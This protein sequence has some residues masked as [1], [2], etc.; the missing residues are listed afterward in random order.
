MANRA[1]LGMTL[2]CVGSGSD[3]KVRPGRDICQSV[4]HKGKTRKT[5]L[6]RIK[7]TMTEKSTPPL[8]TSGNPV[9]DNGPPKKS[10]RAFDETQLW[11]FD[12]VQLLQ[13]IIFPGDD[14]DWKM[15]RDKG[16]RREIIIQG[17]AWMRGDDDEKLVPT[18]QGGGGL[19]AKKFIQNRIARHSKLIQR[20]FRVS[21]SQ[22]PGKLIPQPVVVQMGANVSYSSTSPEALERLHLI[23][24]AAAVTLQSIIRGWETRKKY[25]LV[26]E[27][28]ISQMS[29]RASMA[30]MPLAK[31]ERPKAVYGSWEITVSELASL[32][33]FQNC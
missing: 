20:S 30:G 4:H 25:L 12:P 29:L 27:G 1:R 24:S 33:I 17:S 15:R 8:K 28:D 16:I 32:V 26:K 5:T 14:L 13:T 18:G 10:Q 7:Q 2:T 23:R 9:G 11:G 19:Q 21:G 3:E 31:G 22:S 6:N